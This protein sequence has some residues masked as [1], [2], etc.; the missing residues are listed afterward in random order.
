M[1]TV[2]ASPWLEAANA[3]EGEAA[4]EKTLATNGKIRQVGSRSFEEDA[5]YIQ[6]H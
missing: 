1:G 4:V 6:L 2:H 5:S 3:A